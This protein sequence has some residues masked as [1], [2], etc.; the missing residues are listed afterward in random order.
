MLTT[1]LEQTAYSALVARFCGERVIGKVCDEFLQFSRIISRPARIAAGIR[2]RHHDARALMGGEILQ[3]DEAG[4]RTLLLR[5]AK[6][7]RAQVCLLGPD[8]AAPVRARPCRRTIRRRPEHAPIRP[9]PARPRRR[10]H[11]QRLSR[12][13]LASTCARARV[14]RTRARQMISPAANPRGWASGA[15]RPPNQRSQAKAARPPRGR[16]KYRCR[17]R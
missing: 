15:D 17:G 10:L 1:S 16:S 13:C 3:R 8:A 9:R 2:N 11:S 5:R 6:W 4:M 14:D 7:N 12:P